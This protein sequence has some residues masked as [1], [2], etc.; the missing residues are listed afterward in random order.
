MT[1]RV[2]GKSGAGS[3]RSSELEADDQVS[4]RKGIGNRDFKLKVKIANDHIAFAIGS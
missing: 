4:S 3:S 2:R 1:R